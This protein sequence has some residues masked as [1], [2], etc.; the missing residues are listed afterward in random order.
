MNFVIENNILLEYEGKD[1]NV[2]IPEGVKKISDNVFMNCSF[3][4]SVMLPDSLEG[5]GKNAFSGCCGLTQITF[6]NSLKEL[7]WYAF[8][9]CSGLTEIT[10]TDNLANLGWYTFKDCTGI[11][12]VVVAKT[13]TYFP[14][15]IFENCTSLR[16]VTFL[17]SPANIKQGIHWE[18]QPTAL[19]NTSDVLAYAPYIPI[20]D[21]WFKSIRSYAIN[22][23]VN[24]YYSGMHFDEDVLEANKKF[25]NSQRKKLYSVADKK[26]MQ[27]MMEEKIIPLA[28]IDDVIEMVD[29]AEEKEALIEYKNTNFTAKQ[30]EKL[31]AK[32]QKDA[33]KSVA[34]L[35]TTELKKEWIFNNLDDGTVEI[36]SYKGTA[37]EIIIPSMFG[38]KKITRIGWDTFNPKAKR[39][40]NSDA[41]RK[42][43]SV[44]IPEGITE[45][46]ES[47]FEG[48]CN[49]ENITIPKSLESIEGYAFYETKWFDKISE[50]GIDDF[51]IINGI[52][53]LYTGTESN[54]IVPEGVKAIGGLAFSSFTNQPLLTSITL[55][56]TL[57]RLCPKAFRRCTALSAIEIPKSVIQ[58]DCCTFKDCYGLTE[59]TIPDGIDCLEESVFAGCNNLIS[60]HIPNSV[61]RIKEKAFSGCIS[62][63]KPE[64]AEDVTELGSYAFYQ[65]RSLKQFI[66]PKGVT[67]I[68]YATF[69]YC[70]GLKDIVIPESVRKIEHFAFSDCDKL[71]DIVIPDGVITI[72]Q[73]VFSYGPYY[74]TVSIPASTTYIHSSVFYNDNEDYIYDGMYNGITIIAP[75]DSYGVQFAKENELKC[76]S[77][78]EKSK[79]EYIPEEDEEN[80]QNETTP[81]NITQITV[82]SEEWA[83]QHDE[84]W[85]MLVPASGKCSTVQGE[86]VR[87]GGK[88]HNEIMQNAGGNWDT[89]YMKMLA[90]ISKYYL[91]GQIHDKK[92]YKEVI[93]LIQSIDWNS[94]GEDILRLIELNVHWVLANPVPI[95]LGKVTY[96]R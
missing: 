13:T 74:R 1:E 59:I 31:K 35:S 69:R 29:D 11:V 27:Y 5:I 46:G 21:S 28:D 26:L 65:C 10:F 24:A 79:K 54:V 42:I 9:G 80:V 37:T 56:C 75:P 58:I 73:Q 39:I 7:G 71:T 15:N 60:A 67:K 4:K 12:S 90:S 6:P 16:N 45:I 41:R 34:P 92:E 22:G 77:K 8:C 33:E 32:K 87:I 84:L 78:R 3:I 23:F 17:N 91:M 95:P 68:E 66:V 89:D 57:K 47:A 70:K 82:K 40:K 96:R 49:L 93:E 88:I 76:I 51:V 2:V 81:I 20:S 50:E 86:V 62:L 72:G 19:K 43:T 44:V 38:K 61:K 18:L 53:T 83:D 36:T 64:L 25:I 94:T 63:E 52:L 14:P 85:D 55:P 30:S 48:C